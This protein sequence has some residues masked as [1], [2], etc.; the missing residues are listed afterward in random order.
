MKGLYENPGLPDFCYVDFASALQKS[1]MFRNNIIFIGAI[2]KLVEKFRHYECYS[3]YF[4]YTEDLMDYMKKNIVEGRPS[5]SGYGGML[6]AN[7][8]PIDIDC[9]DELGFAKESALMALNIM[10]SELGI[11]GEAV[12]I[13]FSGRK[14]FHLMADGRCFGISPCKRLNLYFAE[15]RKGLAHM[16]GQYGATLDQNLSDPVRLWRL[17]NTINA[18]SGLYKIQL[19]EDELAGLS[20]SEIRQKS[21]AARPLLGTDPTG[22]IPA[23]DAPLYPKARNFYV[24]AADKVNDRLSSQRLAGKSIWFQKHQIGLQTGM[25][26][27]KKA[28]YNSRI[29]EG[30][31]N[32]TAFILASYFLNQEGRDVEA[33]RSLIYEWN[34]VNS[35][36][37]D[38]RELDGVIKSASK[39]R[40]VFGC[41]RLA[42]YCPYTKNRNECSQYRMF[43]R[44]TGDDGKGN[45]K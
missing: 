16:M 8:F 25:C 12:R 33:T 21:K 34:N 20:A 30:N 11:D 19:S 4:L 23:F 29:E 7:F 41:N 40:Y 27:A 15:M 22:L 18:K 6:H 3:T 14:G 38:K 10:R 9:S 39:G 2:P 36:G 43:R 26:P 13:Y 1:P 31:R 5:V 35:I 24:K 28:I 37:L 45:K 42:S 44:I 17:P 32:N